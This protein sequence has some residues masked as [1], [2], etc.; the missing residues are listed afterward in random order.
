VADIIAQ[1]TKNLARDDNG[2]T[3]PGFE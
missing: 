2:R 3:Y 1:K